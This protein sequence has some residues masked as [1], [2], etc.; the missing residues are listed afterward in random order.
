MS[1]KMDTSGERENERRAAKKAA[2]LGTDKKRRFPLMI[3][4]AFAALI[5]GGGIFV[6]AQKGDEAPAVSTVSEAQVSAEVVAYPAA[7][8]GDGKAKYYSYPAGDGITVKYFVLKS[9]DGVIRAAFD[10]CDV[11]W[12]AGKGY[13]QEGDN[14]VCRNCGRRFPSVKVN[15]VKGGCNPAPLVRQLRDGR[16]IIRTTDILAGKQ[17]FDFSGKGAS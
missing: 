4:L 5:M 1:G 17:Y 16:V 15:E 9:S 7:L 6:L 10:A 11:C 3:G 8:F 13:A 2:V 12:R 14:M